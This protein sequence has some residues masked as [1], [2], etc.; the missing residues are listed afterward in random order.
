MAIEDGVNGAASW[1]FDFAR[2]SSQEALPDLA[3]APVRLF[4]LGG[5][6]GGFDLLG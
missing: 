2:Q 3:G 6:D 5:N 4:A 1:D